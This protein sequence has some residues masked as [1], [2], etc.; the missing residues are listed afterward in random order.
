MK[1]KLLIMF[2][3]LSL[4]SILMRSSF[5][6]LGVNSDGTAPATNA[7]LDVS[8][9]SKGLLMPRM[10]T[11][12]RTAITG[13]IGLTV[14]DTDI[15]AYFYHNGSSWQQLLTTANVA[16]TTPWLTSGDHIYNSNIANVGIGLVS[17][18]RGKLEVSGVA[19]V[20][21]TNAI[22]GTGAS[23]ISLQQN[24]PTIGFNQ[25]R[26][27]TA[28]Q[29][30]YMA[31]GFAAI[32]YFDPGGGTMALDMF[33]NGAGNNLT[34]TGKRALTIQ[35]NGN[36]SIAAGAANTTLYVTK[37]GNFD[38][39]AIFGGT[40]YASYFNHSN[41]EDT[42]IRPG[43]TVGKVILNDLP[44]AKIQVGNGDGNVGIN[45][46]PAGYYNLDIAQKLTDGGIRLFSPDWNNTHWEL[47]NE[48]YSNETGS[49]CLMFMYLGGTKAWVRPT[50]GG[51]SDTSDRRLK[52]NIEGMESVLSKVMYLKPSR[53][54]MK[55]SNPSNIK[56]LGFI[57]Q[58]MIELFPEVVDILPTKADP[59]N[60]SSV[61]NIMGINYSQLSVIALKAIQEQQAMILELKK[62]VALLKN[63][64]KN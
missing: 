56:S 42:Y 31:N 35:N 23:G 52:R 36:V 9:T 12:Q 6:Q 4:S 49:S 19:G 26:D 59:S 7:M 13:T 28:G 61:D 58:E 18:T 24:W 62:E 22:F 46:S 11:G 60:P 34:N 37:N 8:S 27:N 55:D 33:A 21:N 2:L 63:I 38:G 5:A 45:I 14:Y 39:T 54:E 53:Y 17:P 64:L 25:Y 41:N 32:Q 1:I 51:H 44:G 47:R 30:K 43:R 10:N 48:V 20:G 40:N 57:A 29:G 16:N 15:K 3:G 50:D